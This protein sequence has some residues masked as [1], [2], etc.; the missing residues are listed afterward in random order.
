MSFVDG[1]IENL[2]NEHA[3]LADKLSE[4][5][6]KEDKFNEKTFLKAVASN[7]VYH[8]QACRHSCN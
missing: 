8:A 4:K 6:L 1:K 2:H 5:L 3:T 7:T